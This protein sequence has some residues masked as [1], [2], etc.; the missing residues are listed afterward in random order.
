VLF[1]EPYYET[2][3]V[4]LMRDGESVA[5]LGDLSSKRIMADRG[6]TSYPAALEQW[7]ETDIIPKGKNDIWTDMLKTGEID[8]F[9]IDASDQKRVESEFGIKLS[10]VDEPLSVEFFGIAINKANVEL[11]EA[12]DKVIAERANQ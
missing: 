3:I 6:T 4:A 10:K 5:S 12:L 2:S 7:P 8:A 11:K 9:I 1:S